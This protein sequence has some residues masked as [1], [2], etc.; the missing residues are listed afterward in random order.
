MDIILRVQRM[1]GFAWRGNS[2]C[3]M[4]LS[5]LY[6]L[7][8]EVC[9]LTNLSVLPVL[10]VLTFGISFLILSSRGNLGQHT[11]VFLLWVT[12]YTRINFRTHLDRYCSD[13]WRRSVHFPRTA[14][15]TVGAAVEMHSRYIPHHV[16]SLLVSEDT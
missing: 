13:S 15:S 12:F 14:G 3:T 2:V 4:D 5:G 10:S 7:K 11:A 16:C 8:L 9:T 6:C 1:I